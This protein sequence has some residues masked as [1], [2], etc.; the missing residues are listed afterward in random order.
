MPQLLLG[1]TLSFTANPW[2]L[3]P[4]EAVQHIRQGAVL[5]EGGKIT[6]VGDADTLKAAHPEA[7]VTDHGQSLL[8][9]GFIDSHAHFSQTAIIASWGKRLIDW[10]NTYTFPEESRFSDATYAAEV[11]ETYLDLNLSNGITTACAYCTIHPESVDAYF[12]ASQKR[13]LRMLGGKVMMDRNAPDNLRDT[14]QSG[15]DDSKALLQKWHGK[16]RLSYTISPR[17][18]PTSTPAQLEATGALWAEHPECLMQTHLSEQHEELAWVRELFPEHKDYLA[19]YEHYGLLGPGAIMGHSIYLSDREWD[20]IRDA[21]ASIAHCP[22]S[23][24]FIGS[25]LFHATRAHAA[26]IRTGLATDVGGGSSFSM[27]RTMASAYEIGQLKGDALHPAQLLYMA[28]VGSAEAL[29]IGENVGNLEAGKEADIIVINLASTPVIAQRTARADTLWE[30][31]FPTI[32]LG[33]DRAIEA[34]Y[35]AGKRH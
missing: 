26:G 9:A 27:L 6:A 34:V 28:T 11:A 13:G 14:A 5:V 18:A 7:T 17:F 32:M 30:A 16:D 29:H 24:A 15:Y 1:Q 19:V 21:G 25:G 12:E 4:D 22:T 31:I 33:D 35:V 10:L 20:A 8:M 2:L 3:P 23:N